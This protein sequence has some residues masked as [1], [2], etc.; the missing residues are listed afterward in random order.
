MNCPTCGEE[1]QT[2]T[3]HDRGNS[4]FLPAGEVPPTLWTKSV[5]EKKHAVLLPPESFG[6]A[7]AKRPAAYWCGR[8]RNMLVDYSSLTPTEHGPEV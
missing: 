4:Y 2:G 1:M 7:W 8:C 6:A 5:L 3:F